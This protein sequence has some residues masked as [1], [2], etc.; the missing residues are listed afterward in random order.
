MTNKVNEAKR[1]SKERERERKMK[2]KR[3]SQ[4]D[5][6]GSEAMSEQSV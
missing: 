4:W 1:E 5:L 2:L 6:N 3:E